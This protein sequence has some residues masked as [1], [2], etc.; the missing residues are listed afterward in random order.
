MNAH[1]MVALCR[2]QPFLAY[3]FQLSDWVC[4][5]KIPVGGGKKCGRHTSVGGVANVESDRKN[6]CE[7]KAIGI[8][9]ATFAPPPVF[10]PLSIAEMRL[11]NTHAMDYSC[12]AREGR[13]DCCTRLTNA[14]NS[15]MFRFETTQ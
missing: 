6:T 5:G 15:R 11:Y 14:C 3:G 1:R 9:I 12:G 8:T 13:A 10:V 4:Q 2:R 7:S